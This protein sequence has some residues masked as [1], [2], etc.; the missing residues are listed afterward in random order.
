MK[1]LRFKLTGRFLLMG[2]PESAGLVDKPTNRRVTGANRVVA[3]VNT[4]DMISKLSRLSDESELSRLS[5]ESELSRL[6]GLSKQGVTS[7]TG[8]TKRS[9]ISR[10]GITK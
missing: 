3:T 8:T 5:G 7:P 4:P 2:N 6:S 9:A 1:L 10:T